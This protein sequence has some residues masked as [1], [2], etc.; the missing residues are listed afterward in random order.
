[1][2]ASV[3][4]ALRRRGARLATALAVRAVVTWQ[5]HDHPLLQP[6]GG[7]DSGVYVELGRG[8]GPLAP[9][10]SNDTEEGRAYNRRVVFDRTDK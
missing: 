4:D 7:L 6:V 1:M 10:A 2:H 3:P 8:V 9:V 5:L